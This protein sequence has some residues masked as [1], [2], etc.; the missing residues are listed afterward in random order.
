MRVEDDEGYHHAEDTRQGKIKP[1]YATMRG[2][3]LTGE[4]EGMLTL[5]FHVG[6]DELLQRSR[7]LLPGEKTERLERG[8]FE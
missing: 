1:V 6:L 5:L 8:K 4:I 2:N 7:D 3:S